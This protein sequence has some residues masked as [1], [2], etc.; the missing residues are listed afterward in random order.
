MRTQQVVAEARLRTTKT[1]FQWI[2]DYAASDRATDAALALQE[3]PFLARDEMVGVLPSQESVTGWRMLQ[4]LHAYSR[5]CRRRL[6][7]S[8]NIVL[9]LF[10]GTK[11]TPQVTVRD[12]CTLLS[13]C[14]AKRKG[15]SC[16]EC[17]GLDCP[18]RKK[19]PDGTSQKARRIQ[20][21]DLSGSRSKSSQSIC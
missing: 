14:D 2:E 11:S 6:Q 19:G 17:C 1:W 7:S 16:V 4:A 3:A 12:D 5:R 21:L 13:L 8:K 20:I 9:H 10:S 15:R 18:S